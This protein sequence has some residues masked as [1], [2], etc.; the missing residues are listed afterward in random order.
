MVLFSKRSEKKIFFPG[1]AKYSASQLS[2]LYCSL[3]LNQIALPVTRPVASSQ[4]QDNVA[5]QL[6]WSIP[7]KIQTR[8]ALRIYFLEKKPGIFHFF[9]LPLK[10]SD[11]TKLT[12][13]IFHKI[14]LDLLE[15][16]RPKTKT[17]GNSTLFFLGQPWKLHMLFL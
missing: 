14:V 16:P 10:I 17:L 8:G 7:E 15:I 1:I 13:W 4:E 6:E 2:Q 5:K 9:T 11:K 12:P 3:Q